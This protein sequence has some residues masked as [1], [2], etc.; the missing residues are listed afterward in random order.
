MMQAPAR[1]LVLWF[2]DWPVTA[3]VREA[4]TPPR[5]DAAI[6]VFERNMVVACSAAARAQGV[7]RGQRRRGQEQGADDAA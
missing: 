1:S 6:A 7:R 5:A 2:P 3:L 4:T